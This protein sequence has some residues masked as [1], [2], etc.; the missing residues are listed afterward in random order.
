[1]FKYD[2]VILQMDNARYHWT[3]KSL[4][5]YSNNE[6]KVIDWPL[7]STDLKQIENIWAFMKIQL[8]R[9]K[10]ATINSR[11]SNMIFSKC[12]W[13]HDWEICNEHL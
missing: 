5:L 13:G 11:I 1:M 10:F 9:K 6:I 8:E 4:E 3:T 2:G 7:Y 12:W